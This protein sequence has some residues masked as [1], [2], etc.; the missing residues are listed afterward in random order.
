MKVNMFEKMLEHPFATI[1]VVGV[2]VDGVSVL[3]Y[4]LVNTFRK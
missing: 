3:A 1:L 2:V 4:N